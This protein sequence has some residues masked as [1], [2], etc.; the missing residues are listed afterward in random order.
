MNTVDRLV[1]GVTTVT[2][3]ARYYPLHGL[4][5]A[6]ARDRSMGLPA[7]QDLLRRVEVT[8]GAVSARH[9]HVDADGHAALSRPHGYDI[10]SPRVREGSIDVSSLAAPYV[11]AQPPWGFWSAYRG[12]EMVLRIV[13]RANDIGPGDRLDLHAVSEGLGDVLGLASR[14]TLD[15]DSLDSHAH[16]CI[17]RSISSPDG[18][19]LA[20]LFAAPDAD[21]PTTRAGIRRQTLRMI[22]RSIQL[23]NVQFV[24][25]DVARLLAYDDQAAEDDTLASMDIT[26]EWRGLMLRNISVTAWRDLWA[27]VVNGIDGLTTRATLADRFADALPQG[28]VGAFRA[29]LPPTLTPAGRPAPA[30][31]DADLETADVPHYNLSLLMLGA[32]RAREL[33]GHEL[34]GFQGHDP[35]DI[36]E[37]LAPAWLAGQLDAWNDR[38]VRDFASWLTDVMLNRSQRLALRKARPDVK[39]GILK[40]PT[41]VYLRDGF[42]FC[43][44]A[45]TG[46]PASLRLDQLGGILAGMGLLAREAGTWALGQRG[47][48]LA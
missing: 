37:E 39:K 14:S 18:A 42:V 5:A 23:A 1:P 10:I 44:S 35:E 24:A 12:S 45:E 25:R 31:I 47:D 20:N 4:V 11:Y 32:Q 21:Q 43:D 48:L 28:T 13:T 30:E 33:S 3:N 27:W 2:L 22:A 6:E 16:L 17:C 7:A 29:R 19:W 15:T 8:V 9:L 46:G 38:S 26:A 36:F 40:I 34:H 41:R